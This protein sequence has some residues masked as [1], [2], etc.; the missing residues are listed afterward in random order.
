[1]TFMRDIIGLRVAAARCRAIA[2]SGRADA[3]IY[4]TL[5]QEIDGKISERQSILAAA[6]L[7]RHERPPP[8]PIAA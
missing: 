3:A 1:M 7:A 2:R 5:A 8:M 6:R 4:A